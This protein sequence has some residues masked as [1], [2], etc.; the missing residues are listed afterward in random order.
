MSITRTFEI[1]DLEPD[2][3]AEEFASMG[4]WDQ[5]RFFNR[6]AEITANWDARKFPMQLQYVADSERLTDRGRR[7][8]ELIGEYAGRKS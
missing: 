4:S 6:L 8:M 3:M 5:A 7:V 1:A 2:E